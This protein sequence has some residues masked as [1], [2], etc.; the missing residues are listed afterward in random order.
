MK[1]GKV[2]KRHLKG[3]A[4]AAALAVSVVAPAL[5]QED[6]FRGTIEPVEAKEPYKI[7][8]SA[9][10]FVD[11]FWNAM[12]YGVENEAERSGVE[13]VS[14]LSA[15]GYGSLAK[16]ISDLE[17][18]A[19]LEPD[20]I[21][22]AGATYDGLSRTIKRIS[23]SGIEVIVAGTPVN[24][25]LAAVGILED[26]FLVGKQMGEYLCEKAAGSQVIT[27]PGPQGSEWNRI[28]F[29]GY[30]SAAEECGIESVGNTF[31]G[32]MSLE[33]GQRQAADLLVKY[34]DASYIWAVVGLI[35]DGAA[36][37]VKRAGLTD[38]K[39][40]SSAFTDLTVPMME[41]GYIEAS[42]SEP[43]MLTGRLAVQYMV[44]QLNGDE[45]PNTT[46]GGMPYPVVVVPTKPVSAG[47][48]ANYDLHQFD[49][50]PEDWTNS[51]S[52]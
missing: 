12:M 46:D 5:A 47:D 32:G 39:V 21:I 27:L 25:D 14:A 20:G 10:H 35:G 43:S 30:L 37:A 38:V 29:D 23:E 45:L 7:A 16:Q 41:E 36:S 18:L 26:E 11:K 28:R 52:R 49:W 8:F 9:V 22:V 40:V 15:G 4:A 19:A 3:V 1:N 48:M 33:D 34:P 13:L 2:M 6:R 24:T 44:R 17:S 50:A 51:Y 42:I 31:K